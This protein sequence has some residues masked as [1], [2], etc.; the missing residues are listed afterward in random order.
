MDYQ[1]LIFQSLDHPQVLL[2]DVRTPGSWQASDNKINVPAMVRTTRLIVIPDSFDEF[3]GY[4]I[5]F[6]RF[7]YLKSVLAGIVFTT[8][9][10]WALLYSNVP[11]IWIAS[12]CMIGITWGFTISYLLGLASRFDETGQMAA[13]G[14]F[15]SKM[16]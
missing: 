4:C 15:A 6:H 2:L 3:S 14:G 13:M 7:G 1:C 11:W 10:I 9:A 12:N 8:L 16:G 5:Q